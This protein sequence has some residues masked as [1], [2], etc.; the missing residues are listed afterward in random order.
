[1]SKFQMS[2]KIFLMAVAAVFSLAAVS[3]ASVGY[4]EGGEVDRTPPK[5]LTSSPDNG[6]TNFSSAEIKIIF[7]E[8]VQLKNVSDNVLISP[9]FAQKP[10]IT[11][12]GKNVQIKIKAYEVS[13]L[14]ITVLLLGVCIGAC[15]V[16]SAKSELLVLD[17][18]K[19]NKIIGITAS[20][21]AYVYKM[22]DALRDAAL[23]EGLEDPKYLRGYVR[24]L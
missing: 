10:E 19:M 8:Y 24:S 2:G 23:A 7:D 9:P 13:A 12:N 17:E 22:I 21:P 1:M 11:A 18:S 20:S 15:R 16:L 4:P 14:G 5:P 6:T 3:C